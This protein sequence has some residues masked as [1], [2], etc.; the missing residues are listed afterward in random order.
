MNVHLPMGEYERG[1]HERIKKARAG[2]GCAPPKAKAVVIPPPPAEPPPLLED[3]PLTKLVFAPHLRRSIG[4]SPSWRVILDDVC[5]KHR[6]H[7]RDVLGP[8]RARN[9]VACRHEAMW[10]IYTSTS[11]SFPQIGLRFNRDHS[12]VLH[13]VRKYEKPVGVRKVNKRPSVIHS[14]RLASTADAG[15]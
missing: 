14:L 13:A 10:V 1:L 2:L 12:V 8:S 4:Y 6:L 15:A 9:L 5:K 3:E 7:P 11:M